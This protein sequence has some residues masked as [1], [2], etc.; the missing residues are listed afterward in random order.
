MTARTSFPWRPAAAGAVAAALLIGAFLLGSVR[1]GSSP[2]A[3]ASTSTSTSGGTPAGTSATAPGR[4]TVTGTGT[5][6]G[7]PSELQLSMGVQTSAGSVSGALQAANRAVRA[8]TRALERGGVRAADI[9]T[10]GLSI[11]P[12]YSGSSGV[13]SGY[14]VGESVQVTLR[15]L[16]SAGSQISA[17]ARAGGNATVIDGVSLNLSDTGSL[18][19]SAR[20]RAVADARA[21]AAQYAR[22]LGQR[23]GPVLSMSESAPAQP[24]PQPLYLPAASAG[25]AA[26][27]PVHPGTQQLSVTVTAVFA[28]G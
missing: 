2:A 8:V 12:N 21:K 13:P 23:L 6:T 7:V 22:A 27:V 11:Q 1:G 28:L 19:S 18:L 14:G 25:R 24:F 10:S 9:Q 20:T 16:A 3:A 17:A 15:Q 26:S 5:V 4:V